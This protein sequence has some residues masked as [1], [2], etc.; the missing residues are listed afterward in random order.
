MLKTPTVTDVFALC[1]QQDSPC[2]SVYLPFE[3]TPGG[4]KA[5][6]IALKNAVDAARTSLPA[7]MTHLADQLQVLG[8]SAV[9]HGHGRGL[10]LFVNAKWSLSFNVHTTWPERTEVGKRFTV[11]PL[12]RAVGAQPRYYVL[13][14]SPGH[15]Q[16]HEGDAYDLTPIRGQIPHSLTDALGEERFLP[17]LGRHSAAGQAAVYHGHGDRKEQQSQLRRFMRAVEDGVWQELRQADAPLILACVERNA[18]FFREVCRYPQLVDQTVP[19]NADHMTLA[20]LHEATWPIV[21]ELLAARETAWCEEAREALGTGRGTAVWSKIGAAL[22]DGRLG[23]LMLPL[24]RSCWG[25]IDPVSGEVTVDGHPGPD[26]VELGE[27]LAQAALRQGA[28]VVVLPPEAW[29]GEAPVVGLMR[30]EAT[31]DAP[32]DGGTPVH[33]SRVLDRTLDDSFPASDPPSTY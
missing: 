25:R 6:R 5:A 19:G 28:D 15:V 16:L 8:A 32:D 20:R 21:E 10:A 27:A 26:S 1:A 11:L 4:R 22:R 18:A 12:L 30:W 17:H 29:P 33:V 3:A 24:N 13:A 7:E 31:P 2:V 23:T 14:V 9:E